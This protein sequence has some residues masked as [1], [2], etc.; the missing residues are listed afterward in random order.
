[1]TLVAVYNLTSGGSQLIFRRARGI[2]R[3]WHLN[4]GDYRILEALMAI[5]LEERLMR[6]YEGNVLNETSSVMKS[7]RNFR[8]R[9]HCPG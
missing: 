5:Y 6:H 2:P 1:M 8:L 9:H 7:H 3:N 4:D